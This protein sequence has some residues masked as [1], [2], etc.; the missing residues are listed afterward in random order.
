MPLRSKLVALYA[1]VLALV[2][3]GFS[4]A[5]V[6]ALGSSLQDGVAAEVEARARGL[7]A[8]VEFEGGAWVIEAKTGLLPDF[9][10]G[11]GRYYRVALAD[12][13]SL[14]QSPLAEPLPR[15]GTATGQRLWQDDERR[16]L[17]RTL[18]VAKAGD[19]DEAQ[20]AT[21]LL[22][23]CGLDLREVDRAV[24]SLVGLLLWLGPAVL[25]L[26]LL[27]G[28]WL[29]GRALRP[30]DQIARTAAAIGASDLSLR[31]PVRGR[32]ELAA[33]AA[34][35]NQTFARLQES[36]ERQTRFT[37]DASHEL[38]TPLAAVRGN[39]E[40]L[41]ARQRSADEQQELLGEILGASQQMQALIDGLLTLA[42]ADHGGIA[43]QPVALL[44]LCREVLR[45]EAAAAKEQ[46]VELREDGLQD[47]TVPG[48]TGCLQ[49]LL[50]NLVRNGVRYHRPGGHVLVRLHAEGETAVLEVE[51][52][53]IGIPP[54]ALPHL[55][56]RFFRVDE[57]RARRSG[58]VGLGL[59]IVQ[60]IAAAHGG[61]VRFESRVGDGTKV[62]VT[63][64]RT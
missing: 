27:G 59:S 61:E 29:V 21:T 8:A 36:F 10:I 44:P 48:D 33:L 52:D 20:H 42:R 17:E 64:P 22:V 45:R 6:L 53:G 51:D 19:E 56:E 26:S 25:L 2:I 41:L 11:S 28:L 30:I 63:L 9:A 46:G 54:E 62:R 32:D 57:S 16:W 49:Q 13:T 37:A 4:V 7:G 34:T 1:V 50:T 5:M 55:G 14:L 38:R 43:R 12:G 35:L 3:A 40:L 39:V 31:V 23:T 60:A 18:A 24:A 15:Q 58:G 47:V